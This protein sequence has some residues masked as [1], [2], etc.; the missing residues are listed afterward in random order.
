[1]KPITC[2]DG[3]AIVVGTNRHD[4]DAIVLATGFDA[5]TGAVMNI[6][7]RGEKVQPAGKV[8]GRS[9]GISRVGNGWLS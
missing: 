6:D 5:M 4:V 3:E 8:G 1:M 7:I 2:I 9:Q